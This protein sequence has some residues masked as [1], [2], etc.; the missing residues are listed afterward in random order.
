MTI[1]HVRCHRVPFETYR[2]LFAVLGDISPVVQALP[3]D[4]ALI[5]VTGALKY[6]RRTPAQLA[7]LLQTRVAARYG[8]T[9][10]VGGGNTR[11]AA[12]IA[13]DTC[14]PG[15]VQIIDAHPQAVAAFLD[16]QPVHALPGVGPALDKTLTRYGLETVGDLRALPL[17]TLQRIAGAATGRLL[18][19]RARGID[20]RRISPTGPP[21]TIAAKRRFERDVLDREQVRQALLSL[22]IELG[23]QLRQSRR[24]ARSVELQITYA[25]RS[26]TTRSRTLTEPTSHT[27]A[28][29][30]TLY[31]LHAMLGLERARI[32][33]VTARVGALSGAVG[34]S[35]QLTFDRTVEDART[36]EPVLDKANARFGQGSLLPASL[37]TP[38]RRIKP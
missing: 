21:A 35:V 1:L 15:G 5:D 6:F 37:S 34:T 24:V 27:P 16:P 13:A 11:M 30:Q 12:T 29:Q 33:A 7:D 22:A 32:R 26:S 3:P 10:T 36:L 17:A 19:E 38:T 14:P 31:S 8:L 28:L 2:E 23:A 18:S 4:S 25:D 20:P 9:V